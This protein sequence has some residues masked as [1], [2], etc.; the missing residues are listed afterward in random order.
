MELLSLFLARS[1]QIKQMR[2]WKLII[3]MVVSS[4]GILSLLIT[5][6]LAS[7]LTE[8]GYFT[9]NKIHPDS[10]RGVIIIV[11]TEQCE[12]S[13]LRNSL[14]IYP[15]VYLNWYDSTMSKDKN[16][17]TLE[18]RFKPGKSYAIFIP[19]NLTCNGNLYKETLTTFTM[20]DFSSSIEFAGEGTVIERDS[21]Q[22]AH[23]KLSNVDELIFQGLTI[24]SLLLPDALEEIKKHSSL[25]KLKEKLERRNETLKNNF[26]NFQDIADFMGE[27]HLDQEL[28]FPDIKHNKKQ[29]F[30]IP[31]SFRKNREKGALLIIQLSSQDLL[32][33]RYKSP[34]VQSPARLF[35][36]T[37]LGLAYK[38]TSD[39]LLI[40][41]T[42]LRTGK[43]LRD[44]TIVAFSKDNTISI[45]G[46]TDRNGILMLNNGSIM[47]HIF[48]NTGHK[49]ELPLKLDTITTLV[50]KTRNDVSYIT[51]KQQGNIKPDW[52]N[53][54]ISHEEEQTYLRGYIFTERGIYRPGD[55]VHF[56]GTVRQYDGDIFAPQGREVLFG[57]LNSKNEK[58]YEEKS[59]LSEFGTASGTFKTQSFF[60][61]GTYTIT[62]AYSKEKKDKTS[63]T[64]EIQ[65]FRPP[66]HFVE[67]H[68]SHGIRKD[69][70][71]I[72][73]N[74]DEHFLKCEIEGKYYAGGPVKHGKV[75]WKVSYRGTRF[76]RDEYKNYTFGH[77]MDKGEEFLES[78]ESILD[79]K[80]HVTVTLPLNKEVISG[81]TALEIVA[82][83]VD[84]DGRA[85][86]ES[87]VFQQ[88]P[89]FLVGISSHDETIR[90]GESENLEIIVVNLL[91]NKVVKGTVL[92]EVMEK[93]WIYVKKRN[94]KGDAFWQW[95]QVWKKQMSTPL[96]IKRG[97]ATY[98]FDFLWGGQYFLKFTYRDKKGQDYI[99]ST[100][101]TVEGN[102]YGHDYE[103]RQR[104]FQKLSVV[105]D[106][107]VTSA[108]EKV[109]L[110][111][112]PHQKLS[113]ILMTVERDTII[114]YEILKGN[115]NN[116]TINIEEDYVPNIY[117]SFLGT[118]AREDFPV[119]TG[120]FDDQAPAFLFGVVNVDVNKEVGSLS[121]HINHHEDSFE[122]VPGQEVSFDIQVNN[123]KGRGVESETAF[124]V[125][126]ESVL[127]MTGYKTPSLD[128]LSSFTLPLSVFTDDLRIELLKQT[129]FKYISE[130]VLTGGGGLSKGLEVSAT[131]LRKD[132]RPLA[133]FNPSVIT[134]K[135]GKARITF[136]VPDTMT[137]YR[138]YAVACDKGSRFGTSEE[139]LKVIKDFYLEPGLP[140][141]FTKGDQFTISVSAFNK[142][143]DTGT[144]TITTDY[145]P[146]V[147][148]SP[149]DKSFNLKDYDRTVI[150]I[151][152]EAHESG[153][154]K[155]SFR[156]EFEGREDALTL[157]VP[158]NSDQLL[159]NDILFGKIR[160]NAHIIYSFPEGVREKADEPL[161]SHD[162]KALLTVSGSPFLH[163]SKG[164]SYLLRYPYGCVEQ[165]SSG[166]IP[167]AA[168]RDL[169]SEGFFPDL[170]AAETDKFLKKGIERLL[171][172]QTDS[173]GFGYWPGDVRPH[174]WGTIYAA[175][176][177]SYAHSA[178]IEIPQT[179]M[180]K[181]MTYLKN[182]LKEEIKKNISSRN[183][184][185][186]AYAAYILSLNNMLDK[187]VFIS[188]YKN[189]G[190]LD[191]ES[192]F[193]I[194]LAAEKGGYLSDEVLKKHARSAFTK[195]RD[196]SPHTRAFY[197]PYR[198]AAIAL[199]AGASLIPE[200]PQTG[201]KAAELLKGVGK[202]GIWTSTSDTGWALIALG[203]Y[204]KGSYFE[205]TT[206]T[207]TLKQTA[208]PE[209]TITLKPDGFYTFELDSESFISSPDIILSSDR[210]IVYMLSVTYPRADYSQNGYSHGLTLH[211]SVTN[212]DGSSL[213]K[214]GDVVK[215]ELD[216]EV[217]DNNYR[218]IVIDDPLPAGLVAINT[219]LK[220]EEHF[221][222]T[223]KQEDG[224]YWNYW[225]FDGGFYRFVPHYFEM[226]DDRVLVFRNHAWKGQYRYAYYA[227][228]VCEGK[229][230]MPPTKIQLM[231]EPDTVAYTAS[232]RI[233]ISGR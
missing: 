144:G 18:G 54:S 100:K 219:A 21:R 67:I 58:V 41:A 201:K 57:V 193:L 192:T 63:R 200:D 197:A 152:G 120:E 51:L 65:E 68:F 128:S 60:P 143:S 93:N 94:D 221:G 178:G 75:R 11:F 127:A 53:Q 83:V 70:R 85:S 96:P 29:L 73:I 31:L 1:S 190:A 105:A 230:V 89:D 205:H 154:G 209:K 20:P 95:Q 36:I 66:R 116:I 160:D 196:T 135:E 119:Y 224:S 207:V 211:K 2:T 98:D 40:W 5:P 149:V 23:V 106:K 74:R 175:S 202:R 46:K 137:R 47:N 217:E 167:L 213:I 112:H 184:A 129:P 159:F 157:T 82:T 153:Y 206:N 177:L 7:S 163:M 182:E 8:S 55:S 222:G 91:G 114:T 138:V 148:L 99:S 218:Y 87:A 69:E 124:C 168:L 56:K 212:T 195:K 123:E 26:I 59:I 16:K 156:G 12:L 136:N 13:K 172:M 103:N 9:I 104:N 71:F 33:T 162:V 229:F 45:V 25:E 165:T 146:F 151:K 228:A 142:T 169:I 6:L 223:Q 72:N 50:A 43:A 97:S 19:N 231:Y 166:I 24:P 76:T 80:G 187:N 191:R 108:G 216:L 232:S 42:S 64:F 220:T 14:K 139:E 130:Q 125:V 198:D 39:S 208:M 126:D 199:L 27:L 214:V 113:N 170:T 155:L 62:M 186:T 102:F 49:E 145:D 147:T 173:G 188:L 81:I 92:A 171:T 15:P 185:F 79:E 233:M 28:F 183:K 180:K 174:L 194:L 115:K 226:R 52:V 122:A 17:L 164:L 48:L 30:T 121:V 61:L 141:F 3:Y 161:S 109:K 227:R 117:I 158:V 215:V 111:L 4:L 110:T 210:D 203:Q 132:F 44:V 37:D 181:A 32:K 22:M 90:A 225:D 131:K 204:F 179:Q 78:G 118:V 84:F 10:E 140:R 88:E 176:A 101:Y 34:D 86:T 134:D 77:A 107:K 38:K 133:Y 189:I 35:R 150:P